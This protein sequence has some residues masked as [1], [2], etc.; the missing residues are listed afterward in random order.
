MLKYFVTS[1]LKGRMDV[2]LNMLLA[3][4]YKIM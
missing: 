4:V 3:I 2:S 1:Y